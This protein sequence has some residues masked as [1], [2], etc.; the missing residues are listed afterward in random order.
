MWVANYGDNS[1]SEFAP[2]ELSRSGSWSPSF[3][4]G[5]D[6]GLRAPGYIAIGPPPSATAPTTPSASASL[7]QLLT[8]AGL[9]RVEIRCK[10]ARCSGLIEIIGKLAEAN[11]GDRGAPKDRPRLLGSAAYSLSQGGTRKFDV[12]LG[13]NADALLAELEMHR[14]DLQLVVAVRG[15]KTI[16]RTFL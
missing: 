14:L 3:I 15:G 10:T 2:S 1:L 9:A 11:D 4:A 16:S 13:K 6:T 12:H 7:F 5:P 8:K